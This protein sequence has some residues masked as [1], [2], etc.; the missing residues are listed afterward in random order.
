M[1]ETIH[2]FVIPSGH[3]WK[4]VRKTTEDVG[5]AIKNAFYA[6]EQANEDSKNMRSVCLVCLVTL[7]G[8]IN[9]FCLMKL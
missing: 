2:K 7:I 1:G 8:Q 4:D 9:L 5:I 3:H 6:I